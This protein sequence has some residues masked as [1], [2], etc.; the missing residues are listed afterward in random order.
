MKFLFDDIDNN[1]ST[2]LSSAI[3]AVSTSIPLEL[4][5]TNST[6]GFL[7]ID[8]END[9]KCEYIYFSSKGASSVT[10]PASGGR[11]QAGSS[12]TSHDSG[13]SVKMVMLR[14]HLKPITEAML[15]GWAEH[16][17]APVYASASSITIPT[18]VTAIFTAGKSVKINFRTSGVKYFTIQS[19]SYGAPNTTINLID[20]TVLN[21][22]IDNIYLDIL[23]SG[24]SLR[25]NAPQGFLINGKI[26]LSVASNNL[27]VALK[28]LAGTDPSTTDPVYCR[29]GDTVRIIT[30]ALSVTKNAATNWCNAGGAEL[31]TKEV[32]YFA[33]LGYNATDGV[34]LGFSRIPYALQY[35]DF[36]ATTTNEI[37]CAISTITNAAA[38]DYYNVI[39]R[40]AATLS[41][42]AGY[43]WSVPTFTA[44]NLIQRPIFE[45]RT[46]SCSTVH[47]GFSAN[48][49]YAFNY[50]I[51]NKIL[52]VNYFI[53]GAGTSNGTGYTI[54]LPISSSD[55]NIFPLSQGLNNSANCSVTPV[56][57]SSGNVITF[58]NGFYGTVWTASG[59]KYAY[60]HEQMFI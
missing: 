29:I 44:I 45:T 36:S 25:R 32:D 43:T 9:A 41:A 24:V 47:T 42:G 38:T 3:T 15:T 54:T 22:T 17:Y 33:Y 48:P 57:Q 8:E 51:V 20:G 52:Y 27:T 31:A 56:I 2:T 12:A 18:D 14:E 21:E 37:Y 13:V 6:K 40:F 28:N 58:Y 46:L 60:F 7:V 16:D 26:V 50:K 19:S 39:G 5:P 23:P 34:V 4:V 49:T 30:A 11:G 1:F 35:S 10:C 53:T 55:V 59:S